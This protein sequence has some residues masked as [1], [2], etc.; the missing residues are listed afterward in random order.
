MRQTLIEYMLEQ[1]KQQHLLE[2]A[3]QEGFG[4]SV[5]NTLSRTKLY[6][7]NILKGIRAHRELVNLDGKKSPLNNGIA[8]ATNQLL[9]Q[10]R[11]EYHHLPDNI[12][13]VV[14]IATKKLQLPNLGHS[15]VSLRRDY[16]T[17]YTR[18]C[19]LRPIFN[20]N[21]Q[22]TTEQF[23]QVVSDKFIDLVF[24]AVTGM[25]AVKTAV[26]IATMSLNII[27]ATEHMATKWSSLLSNIH[28][29]NYFYMGDMT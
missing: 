16:Y 6:F 17:M 1:Q 5:L 18:L 19:L 26:D 15:G 14:D 13:K 28:T 24:D 11:N 2:Q 25:G 29:E 23:K 4:E 7:E 21:Y 9:V 3:L 22:N 8:D 12:K 20:I 27:K 10:L